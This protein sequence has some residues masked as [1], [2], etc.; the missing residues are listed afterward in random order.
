MFQIGCLLLLQ[1]FSDNMKKKCSEL[2]FFQTF[3]NINH[4]IISPFVAEIF[5]Y[6]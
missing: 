5:T 4:F 6:I 3:I 1:A 2:N